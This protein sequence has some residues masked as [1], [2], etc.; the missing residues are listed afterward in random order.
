LSEIIAA[1]EL[2]RQAVVQK[3]ENLYSNWFRVGERRPDV[4]VMDASGT[5]GQVEAWSK[6][7]RVPHAR[8]EGRVVSLC[9]L[10]EMAAIDDVPPPLKTRACLPFNSVAEGR[11]PEVFPQRG[12]ARKLL[13]NL[14]RQ[15][16]DWAMHS[17][18]LRPV[19][20]ASGLKG[21]FFP[22]GLIDGPVKRR[23]P[24]GGRVNRVLSGK[25]KERRWHLCLVA[26]PKLWPEP[27]FRVHANVAVTTNGVE[28]LP[29]DQ[30][31]RL[32]LRLTRSWWNNKWRDMLLAAMGWLAESNETIALG[33]TNE[34][35]EVESMPITF[36]FPVS[37]NAEEERA[38]EE[39]ADGSIELSLDLDTEF[40]DDLAED[41]V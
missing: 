29:G 30:L 5:F 2:G 4:W 7:T 3:S 23:L 22:D 1:Q 33:I 13:T 37:F 19:E 36:D 11:Y 21:W 6:S 27:F 41:V 10:G 20:F 12:E 25:F 32:R 39:T 8:F 35:L 28:P 40:E 17:R 24:S 9:P 26:Q 18:G 38:S 15:H 31:Q 14:L 34:P 16:W